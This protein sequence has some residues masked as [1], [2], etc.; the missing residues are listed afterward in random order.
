M[1]K[2]CPEKGRKVNAINGT[3][4]LASPVTHTQPSSPDSRWLR[5]LPY[6]DSLEM[7]ACDT[8]PGIAR[9]RIGAILREWG[10]EKFI[11][12]A[13]L[14]ASE[15]ITNAVA[16]TRKVEWA[17][18]PP[19]RLR[20]RGGP[21]LLVI[22][23]WDAVVATPAPRIATADDESGRGLAIVA[24][25]SAS[26]GFHYP[27]KRGGKATWAII[28]TPGRRAGKAGQPVLRMLLLASLRCRQ[29]SFRAREGS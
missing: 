24:S 19:V 3:W 11:D 7:D 22:E 10:L 2:C 29:D 6:R 9:K 16:E 15:L 14:I 13:M 8:A 12:D 27:E 25:L 21:S 1:P 17:R 20:L 23:I 28:G 26:W 4:P 5:S 18:R